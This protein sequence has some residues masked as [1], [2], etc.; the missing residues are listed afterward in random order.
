MAK[1]ALDPTSRRVEQAAD[2]AIDRGY[3]IS[4]LSTL[5][6]GWEYAISTPGPEQT[7]QELRDELASKEHIDESWLFVCLELAQQHYGL[8]TDTLDRSTE[9]RREDGYTVRIYRW[10]KQ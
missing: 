7:I 2:A 10:S 1:T 3:G 9:L 4:I 8:D 6:G 5:V